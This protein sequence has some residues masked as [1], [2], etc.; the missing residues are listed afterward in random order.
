MIEFSGFS[1]VQAHVNDMYGVYLRVEETRAF[2]TALM[3]RI[4]GGIAGARF[5]AGRDL[6]AGRDYFFEN[7]EFMVRGRRD[8]SF[9]GFFHYAA[10]EAW[11]GSHFQVWEWEHADDPAI[12]IPIERL[13]EQTN[14]AFKTGRL[15]DYLDK[16]AEDIRKALGI[17]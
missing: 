8:P 15:A 6:R 10:P 1:D 17:R 16:R 7:A 4:K 13:Q 3:M 2:T 12:T 9:M 5:S 14:E 11:L